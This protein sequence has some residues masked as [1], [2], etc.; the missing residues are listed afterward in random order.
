MSDQAHS[1]YSSMA[2]MQERLTAITMAG[3]RIIS[4]FPS[5]T[6]GS[7][8]NNIFVTTQVVIV[9]EPK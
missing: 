7:L 8:C 2:K 1:I 3:G 6:E 5:M 9:Y 4:V